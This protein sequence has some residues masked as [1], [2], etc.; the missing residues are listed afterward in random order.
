[1]G[2]MR[3]KKPGITAAKISET[4]RQQAGKMAVV[5]GPRRWLF[6]AAALV[7][8]PVLFLG[9]L[10]LLLRLIG[11][12]YPNSFFLHL[13]INGADSL[14]ENDRFGY[15]FFGPVMARAPRVMAFPARKPADTIRIFVL[16]ESAAFGDPQPEFGLPR[17]LEV[18]LHDRYPDVKCEVINTAMTAINS[19]VILPIAR[20]C[21]RQNGD[22]WVLYMGNNEVIGPYGAG[23]V[24]GSKA[25]NLALLRSTVAIKGTKTGQLLDNLRQRL[26]PAVKEDHEWGG[27]MM[28]VNQ[29][30]RPDDPSMAAVYAH[31]QRNL[32]DIIKTG[33]R[34]GVRLVVSTVASNLKDCPPF[35]SLHRVDVSASSASEWDKLYQAGMAA[36]QARQPAQ[37][38]EW[39]RQAEQI[40]PQ[41][42]E[43]HFRWAQCSLAL[44][45]EEEAR[46]HFT[47]ARDCDALWFRADSRL[48]GLIRKAATGRQAEGIYLADAQS[49]LAQQSPHGVAGEELFYEHVHLNFEGNYALARALVEQV[50]QAMPAAAARRGNSPRTWLSAAECAQR[51]AWAEWNRYEAKANILMRLND[52]PFTLQMN[53]AEQCLQL[54][55]EL[56][57]LRFALSPE[58]LRLAA[59]AC[60]QARAMAPEDWVL[61]E[62]LAQALAKLGDLPTASA[63]WQRVLQRL[64]HHE[65]AHLQRGML[66]TQTGRYDEGIQEFEMALKLEPKSV[67]AM[68]GIGRAL[69]QQGNAQAAIEQYEKVLKLKPNYCETLVNLGLALNTLGKTDESR[70][71]IRQA[72]EH[73]PNNPTVL[74][75]LAKLCC[76]Q[77]WLNEAVTTFSTALE[78]DPADATTHLNLGIALGALGRNTEA[79]QHYAEAARLNPSSA[80]A[81][82]RLGFELGRQGK[83]TGAMEQFSEAVRLKPDFL[84]ARLNLGIA[85]YK[86]G[87]S[88]EAHGHFREAL[89]LDPTNTVALNYLRL[90]PSP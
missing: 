67:Q 57:P 79:A 69:A 46:Q 29:K 63:A 62:L 17:M 89:R 81:H 15:R 74:K 25:P 28:F 59:R 76:T 86:N 52:A 60:E 5:S 71:R 84:E 2:R 72:L 7:I 1:M 87:K 35:A 37:A 11:Y 80:E 53:H 16:G 33:V 3:H 14:I 6:R 65:Q 49:A 90:I 12:G 39:F 54:Q 51:L 88:Q 13:T 70:A 24:F 58:A 22:I 83:E 8:L 38:I 18:L 21:A 78:L 73:K 50:E 43:L 32:A 30:L 56:E 55:R 9:G 42:A 26:A 27:L 19:N 10:E 23:T 64:P 61:D 34:H 36:Q 68:D 82:F 20:D 44:S 85:L 45:R 41:F 66:L 75:G 40:D 48:N 4:T 77:G 47:L 31:F